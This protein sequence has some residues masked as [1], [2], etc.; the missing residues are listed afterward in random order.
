MCVC[1]D[2]CMCIYIYIYISAC[3]CMDIKPSI[4]IKNIRTCIYLNTQILT[5]LFASMPL[6]APVV[7][8]CGD[9]PTYP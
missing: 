8:V 7:C 5:D 4:S 2:I 9:Q 6:F 1:M 3:V